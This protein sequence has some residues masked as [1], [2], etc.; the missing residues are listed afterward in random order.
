[1]LAASAALGRDGLTH[2]MLDLVHTHWKRRRVCKV[3]CR[4]VPTVDMNN[5]C[6][7][8]EVKKKF[9]SSF[10]G[11]LLMFLLLQKGNIC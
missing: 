5:I 2:N 7:H 4:G 3:R 11:H 9:C 8:L 6:Y 10:F 1:M